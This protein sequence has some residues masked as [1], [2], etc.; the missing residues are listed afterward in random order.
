M[1]ILGQHGCRRGLR[2]TA[3]DCATSSDKVVY[4]AFAAQEDVALAENIELYDRTKLLDIFAKL[5]PRVLLRD[6]KEVADDGQAFN[7]LSLTDSLN[8]SGLESRTFRTGQRLRSSWSFGRPELQSEQQQRRACRCQG[9]GVGH[10]S[11]ARLCG[12]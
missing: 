8:R 3:I 7:A 2:S 5:N 4:D 6:L 10:F 9:E 12:I 11:Q 1:Q